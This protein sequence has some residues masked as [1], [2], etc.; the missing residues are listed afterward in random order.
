L[1]GFA[2]AAEPRQQVAADAGQ[3]VVPGQRRFGGHQRVRCPALWFLHHKSEA[4]MTREG[5]RERLCLMTDDDSNQPG[6]DSGQSG[7]DDVA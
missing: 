3:V 1:W 5:G 4:L 6:R 2:I 7:V